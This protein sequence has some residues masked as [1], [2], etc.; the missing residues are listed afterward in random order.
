MLFTPIFSQTNAIIVKNR[1]QGNVTDMIEEIKDA[2]KVR[3]ERK[4]WL[5]NETKELCVEK[6]DA[7]SEMV[8]YPDN[9]ENDTY[10]DEVYEEVRRQGEDEGREGILGVDRER[11]R[12]NGRKDNS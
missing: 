6:V 12:R 5:D 2:F 7:I 8:A 4:S 1:T 3:L 10:L 11:K 9:I